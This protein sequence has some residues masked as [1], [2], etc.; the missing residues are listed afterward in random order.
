MPERFEEVNSHSLRYR[1]RVPDSTAIRAFVGLWTLGV[2]VMAFFMFMVL[3]LFVQRGRYLPVISVT[4]A[5]YA[6][7]VPLFDNRR[8]V[9]TDETLEVQHHPWYLIDWQNVKRHSKLP[10]E[11]PLDAITTVELVD[12]LAADFDDPPLRLGH[13]DADD[14]VHVETDDGSAYFLLVDDPEGLADAIS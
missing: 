12:R 4:V 7:A 6:F 9:V 2:A 10:V 5:L 8:V 11:I 13:G 14:G 3:L 1:L